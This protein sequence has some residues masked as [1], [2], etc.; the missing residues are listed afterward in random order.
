MLKKVPHYGHV[1]TDH[2]GMP[3]Y[4]AAAWCLLV[5]GSLAESTLKKRLSNID[6]FYQH[7]E[8][9]RQFG[10]LDDALGRQDLPLMDAIR[11][12]ALLPALQRLFWPAALLTP[13]KVREKIRNPHNA[14]WRFPFS[15]CT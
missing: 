9:D 4:W 6:A 8:S 14:P 12:Y 10:F 2:I 11:A 15:L 5:G 1:L 3:R 13:L 7:T